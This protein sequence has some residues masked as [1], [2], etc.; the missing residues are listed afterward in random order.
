[1]NLLPS[2]DWETDELGCSHF[3]VL[4]EVED[5]FLPQIRHQSS[6]EDY[7][8]IANTSSSLLT[9]VNNQPNSPCNVTISAPY[10]NLNLKSLNHRQELTDNG[11]ICILTNT[12]PNPTSM[13]KSGS[14]ETKQFDIKETFNSC[15]REETVNIS[16]SN[17]YLK[18]FI[19][20]L[21][22]LKIYYPA[23]FRFI[24]C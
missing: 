14:K 9:Y 13:R 4:P 1:M 11:S 20:Y 3:L 6:L 19:L 17:C 16:I 7:I 5:F 24:S 21:Y 8:K 2:S 15:T 10:K 22:N 12:L 23:L 18:T